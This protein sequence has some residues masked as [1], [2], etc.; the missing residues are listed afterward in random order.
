MVRSPALR[1]FLRTETQAALRILTS[2]AGVV[3]PG[4]VRLIA[5]DLRAEERK[6]TLRLRLDADV[7][8]YAIVRVTEAFIYNDAICAV[9][10]EVETAAR[11]VETM[12]G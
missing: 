4:I 1:S 11:V 3:Q 6:R 9:E 8:A 7:L 12:L 5:A 10:S 2:R